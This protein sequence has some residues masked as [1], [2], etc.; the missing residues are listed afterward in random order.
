MAKWTTVFSLFIT[1]FSFSQELKKIASLPDFLIETSGLVAIN[2]TVLATHNDG[3]G[4]AEIYFLN[5]KGEV[6]HTLKL[7]DTKNKDWEDIAMNE[8]GDLFVADIGDNQNKRDHVS[9]YKIPA[10][11]VWNKE[12]F[13][14]R[15]KFDYPEKHGTPKTDSLYFDAEAMIAVGD[16]LY[17]FTKNRTDPFDGKVLIYG[18]N[19]SVKR[20]RAKLIHTFELCKGG[21]QTCSITAADYYP[22]TDEVVFITYRHMYRIKNFRKKKINTPEIIR[23]PSLKQREGVAFS[24]DGKTVYVSDEKQRILGGGNLYK[25]EWK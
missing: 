18:I 17:I 14:E 19:S 3:G 7:K 25:K 20:Q 13:P 22:K 2:D 12:V 10:S 8:K 21:W 9:I 11:K 5:L 1:I 24:K 15:L 16:S 6:I 4:K 23:L